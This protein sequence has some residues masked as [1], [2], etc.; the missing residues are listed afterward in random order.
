MNESKEYNT[1]EDFLQKDDRLF[2][3]KIEEKL[4]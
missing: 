4:R 3:D 2:K 1:L